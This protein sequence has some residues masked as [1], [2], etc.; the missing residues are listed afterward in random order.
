MQLDEKCKRLSLVEGTEP[1]QPN[2]LAWLTTE[3]PLQSF[4]LRGA[5]DG[6][7][8]D[9]GGE[10]LRRLYRSVQ[11]ARWVAFETL[12]EAQLLLLMQQ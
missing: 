12:E 3:L 2:E 9:Q 8:I 7:A 4:T 1:S 5:K 11:L 10:E 6:E